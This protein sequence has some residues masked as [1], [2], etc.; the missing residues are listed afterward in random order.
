MCISCWWKWYTRVTLPFYVLVYR[1]SFA[2]SPCFSTVIPSLVPVLPHH[3]VLHQDII[4]DDIK[5]L[6][7][8]KRCYCYAFW[9]SIKQ[10]MCLQCLKC[11]SL[12]MFH[13]TV[14]LGG[15]FPFVPAPSPSLLGG[16]VHNE[17]WRLRQP[18]DCCDLLLAA[19][20]YS[21]HLLPFSLGPCPTEPVNCAVLYIDKRLWG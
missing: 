20:P 2:V 9:E 8:W 3:D 10:E 13:C 17:R 7:N 11:D 4:V 6:I 19:S 1:A 12:W 14:Y 21:E 15:R 16:V 18:L 5:C